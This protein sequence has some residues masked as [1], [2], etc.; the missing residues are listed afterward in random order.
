M[1]PLAEVLKEKAL[2]H[3]DLINRL[4]VRRFGTAPLAEEAALYVM[5]SLASD[6]WK[7]LQA[8]SGKGS[9]KSYLASLSWRL[10]E[11]F[12]RKRF[13][14]VRP[15]LWIKKLGGIWSLLFAL[16]CLERLSV[17]DAVESA[18]CR[19]PAS[20]KDGIE[21]AALSLL[22]RIPECGKQQGLEFSLDEREEAGD[23][24][25]YPE[26]LLEK[27]EQSYLFATIFGQMMGGVYDAQRPEKFARLLND[28]ITLTP[29]ERLLLKLLYQDNVG[30]ARAGKLLDLNRDQV[31]GRVRRLLARLRKDFQRMGLEE[32]LLEILR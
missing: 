8:H 5:D 19:Y 3:W 28:G 31:N 1:E 15:P 29:E 7:R 11:D 27:D 10:L 13:G 17:S 23:L 24:N 30:V 18:A 20:E 26:Q 21:D 9:F 4:A 14:R 32:E 25:A 6:S 22:G 12:S 2:A 16:L